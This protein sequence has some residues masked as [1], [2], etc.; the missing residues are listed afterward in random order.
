MRPSVLIFSGS[1]RAGSLN[2]QL[3]DVVAGFATQAGAQVSRLRLRDYPLPLYSA[4]LDQAGPPPAALALKEI[5]AMHAAWIICSPEYN[6][7]YTG[8]LKNAIDWVSSP[9]KNHPLWSD[10]YRPF[11]GK[12]VGLLSASPGGLG[13]VRSLDPL[14]TL[15][16]NL[17]CWVSPYRYALARADQA[18]QAAEGLPAASAF[19]V[20]EVVRKTLWAAKGLQLAGH[21]A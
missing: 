7:S 19:A 17:R 15:L 21:P 18:L 4:D 11:E 14:Q 2:E 16:S 6:G 5:F 1:N 9:V 12:V 8:L 13:G 20:R 3:A 10:S